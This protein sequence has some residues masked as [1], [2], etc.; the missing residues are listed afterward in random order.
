MCPVYFK[1][2]SIE[3][4][5]ETMAEVAS[6]APDLPFWY[7]HFPAKTGV[8]FNMYEFVKHVDVAGNMP[9]FMGIKFTNEIIMDFNAMGNYKNKKYNMLMGRDEILTSALITDVCDGGVGSTI[10][11]M[12]FNV[13][14]DCEWN[15]TPKDMAK[16]IDLQLKTVMVIEK[17]SEVVPALNVQKSILKMTGIDFGPMRL[18]Q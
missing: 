16:I 7:Y 11:Y 6:G 5:A 15:K 18:P 1:P 8:D 14:I 17:W 10:N 4:L 13:D 3:N 9:N 12:S 2:S